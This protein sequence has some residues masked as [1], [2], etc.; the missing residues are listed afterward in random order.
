MN[1]PAA[2]TKPYSLSHAGALSAFDSPRTRGVWF[3]ADSGQRLRHRPGTTS[4][5]SGSAGIT[6]RHST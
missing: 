2:I 1:S 4:H 6:I 5:T 3:D